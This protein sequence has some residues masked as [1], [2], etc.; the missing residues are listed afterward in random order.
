[1]SSYPSSKKSYQNDRPTIIEQ[2]IHTRP[3]RLLPQIESNLSQN[4]P[5]NILEEDNTFLTPRSPTLL[6]IKPKYKF[7]FKLWMLE[8]F[9]S[10][11]LFFLLSRLCTAD[12]IFWI[13]SFFIFV[14]LSLEFRSNRAY[15]KIWENKKIGFLWGLLFL[16]LKSYPIFVGINIILLHYEFTN[17]WDKYQ[18]IKSQS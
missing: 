10:G 16:H 11:I 8:S 3:T 14:F 1:M 6:P 17:W 13:E 9:A 2:D 12:F 5:H 15:K 4:N 7:K 18:L